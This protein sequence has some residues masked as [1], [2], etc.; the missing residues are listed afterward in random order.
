[1]FRRFANAFFAA[2]WAMVAY[3]V[4]C[5][6]RRSVAEREINAGRD[7]SHPFPVRQILGVSIALLVTAL[8]WELYHNVYRH[9]QRYD[10][11]R[12]ARARADAL[13]RPLI[14]VGDPVAGATCRMFGA[15]SG[16]GDVCMDLTGCPEAPSG[17]ERVGGDA[18]AALAKRPANSAI[19]FVSFVLEYVDDPAALYAEAK[20]VAGGTANLRVL[21]VHPYTLCAMDYAEETYAT[22]WRIFSLEPTVVAEASK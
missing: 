22:K 20:R 4:Y 21:T 10:G 17:V 5:Q 16:Y 15:A 11:Y 19:V 8:L 1:M 7:D 9:W 14:V 3:E 12:W 2:I 6:D 13:E 18:R